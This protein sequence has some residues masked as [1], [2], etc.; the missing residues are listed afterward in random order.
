MLEDILFGQ[1]VMPGETIR[2][3]LAFLG[4]GVAAYYDLFNNKNIPDL[5]LYA[6]L[7]V[8]FLVNIVFYDANLFWFSLAVAAFFSAISYL[9]YRVGQLGGAD[10]FVLAAVMLLLPLHP[11]SIGMTFNLPFIFSIIIFSGVV[12][13]LFVVL[14]FG[15]KLAQGTEAKPNLLFALMLLPYALFAYVYVNSFLFSPVYFLFITVLIL[16]VIFFLMF[17]DSLNRLLA[18]EIA[19]EKLEPE[20]VLALEVMNKD[21]VD[22]YK[23]PRLLTKDAIAKLKEAKLETVWVYTK[24]PP[25]IPFILVGMVLGMLFAKSLLFI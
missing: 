6:F 10:V 1:L 25:F 22:R 21:L 4:V 23:I 5:F 24:L 19:V 17:K 18:E 20:E 15:W 14:Y 2:V 11:S 7:A 3:F 16:A 9:F 12:F 13:A 8:A